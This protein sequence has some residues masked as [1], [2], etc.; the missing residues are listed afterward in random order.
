MPHY[1]MKLIDGRWVYF[2]I[3]SYTSVHKNCAYSGSFVFCFFVCPL[4]IFKSVI[5][6]QYNINFNYNCSCNKYINNVQTL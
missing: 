2:Y 1:L 5:K 6:H 4:Y 3:Y